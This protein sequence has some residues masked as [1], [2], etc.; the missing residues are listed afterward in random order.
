LLALPANAIENLGN[1][2]RLG[3]D[4]AASMEGTYR[5]ATG[6]CGAPSLS[7]TL[8]NL[9]ITNATHENPQTTRGRSWHCGAR[10]IGDC[11]SISVNKMRVAGLFSGI[12]GFELA[13][14]DAG[15]E[16]T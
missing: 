12:G 16:P 1:D 14:S 8:R 9:S 7:W 10:I 6:E 2:A 4:T 15:F 11:S 3:V 13:L 5:I